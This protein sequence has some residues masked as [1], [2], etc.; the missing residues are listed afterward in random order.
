M[1]R[2]WCAATI[3]KYLVAIDAVLVAVLIAN[4]A[5]VRMP[6]PRLRLSL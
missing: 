6:L 4:A 5:T 2:A 3:V 1:Y